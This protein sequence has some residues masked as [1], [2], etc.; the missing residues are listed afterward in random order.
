MVIGLITARG[1][2]KGIPNKNMIDVG[3]RPLLQYSIEAAVACETLDRVFLSTDMPA[4]MELA[5]Q[6]PRLEVPFTRPAELCTD[7]A[8]QIQV[9]QHLFDHLKEAEGCRPEYLVLLQPTCPLRD[10]AEIDAAV[11]L[12]KEQKLESLM[13]VTEAMHHP[14]DYVYPDP[15]SPGEYKWVM[16]SPQWKQRQDFPKV[17]FNTGALYICSLEFLDRTQDFFDERSHLFEMSAETL[18]DVDSAFDLSLL[19]G[20]LLEKSTTAEGQTS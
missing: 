1:G 6:F 17:Y 14:A 3:G 5:T 4:A 20:Y 15:D 16:R 10:P 8:T 2:S 18:F 9:V 19:R 7:D 13:G 12:V 11:R